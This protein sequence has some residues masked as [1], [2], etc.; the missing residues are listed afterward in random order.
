MT[1]VYNGLKRWPQL[2]ALRHP[3]PAARPSREVMISIFFS[4]VIHL[5]PALILWIVA[6]NRIAVDP[7]ASSISMPLIVSL[8]TLPATSNDGLDS[9]SKAET[10]VTLKYS[11]FQATK[12]PEGRPIATDATL[13]FNM[14]AAYDMDWN[15][16]NIPEFKVKDIETLI[17]RGVLGSEAPGG[18]SLVPYLKPSY[19]LDAVN[20]FEQVF[21]EMAESELQRKKIVWRV[22]YIKKYEASLPPDCST[23]YAN[24]GF[25]GLFKIP[26][27]IK[28]VIADNDKA[29]MW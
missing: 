14:E 11:E 12:A 28:D 20:R 29:C 26:F 16:G 13:S 9:K 7:V 5:F 10:V 19:G 18:N 3:M 4:I 22:D 24:K 21:G 6:A 1:T 8:T 17:N 2:Q 23:Y 25:K 15:F 27:L